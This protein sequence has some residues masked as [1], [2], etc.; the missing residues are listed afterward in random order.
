MTEYAIS[1]STSEPNNHVGNIKI[2]QDDINTQILRVSPTTNNLPTDFT[3]LLV[4]FRSK[5]SDGSVIKEKVT[6]V[7]YKKRRFSFTLTPNCW[8][9]L[10]PI[11]AWFTFERPDGSVV[12]STKN[13]QYTVFEGNDRNIPQGNYI[14]DFEEIKRELDEIIGNEDLSSFV[15]S[16]EEVK[17]DKADR[18]PTEKTLEELEGNKAD[19]KEVEAQFAKIGTGWPVDSVASEAE[20]LTKY[21]NGAD[22]PV[23]VLQPDGKTG[24]VYLWDVATNK[25][26]KGALYQAQGIPDFSITDI[27]VK[28]E[29]LTPLKITGVSFPKVGVVGYNE[30]TWGYALYAN[31]EAKPTP[32]YGVT[33]K[34]TPTQEMMDNGIFANTRANVCFWDA[35]GKVTLVNGG[36][37][38]PLLVPPGTVTM[39][40]TMTAYRMP[41]VTAYKSLYSQGY[42]S[43]TVAK[44]DSEI[45]RLIRAEFFKNR[46]QYL[47]S[48]LLRTGLAKTDNMITADDIIKGGYLRGTVLVSD[49][50][51]NG[52]V[53][54]PITPGKKYVTTST[55]YRQRYNINMEPGLEEGLGSV[56]TEF[57]AGPNE[58]FVTMN[59][60]KNE[61]FPVL[62][63]V[64]G[65]PNFYPSDMF[66]DWVEKIPSYLH[67]KL[68]GAKITINGDSLSSQGDY[69]VKTYGSL[70]AEKYGCTIADYGISGTTL[71]HSHDRH[72][73][74]YH[75]GR[76]DGEAIGYVQNDP[77]TWHTGNCMWE[78]VAKLDSNADVV[79]L[80]GGTNDSAATKGETN[81]TDMTTLFGA[82]NAIFTQFRV[83]YAGKPILCILPPQVKGQ[84]ETL[85][86]NA[87]AELDKKL[88]GSTLTLQLRCEVIR[89]VARKHNIPIIDLFNESGITADNVYYLLN[90]TLHL[91]Q[92]GHDRILKLIEAKLLEIL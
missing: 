64:G 36:W 76:L 2:R 68:K 74:D 56:P 79:F 43:Q 46:A 38:S 59:F 83:K 75:F 17:L 29:G 16:L 14:Y 33:P 27:Q 10:G 13:F 51:W 65:D 77:S 22:G 21:P 7:D 54:Q 37:T 57:T 20:L 25:W 9:R 24:Y 71:A 39:Q 61:K 40:L 8:Q 42:P 89:R 1:L 80:M 86:D 90:D 87:S 6:D 26:K 88:P 60:S 82:A 49:A 73:W 5:W 62:M 66:S 41:V 52:I 18:V 81:S 3:G 12:D 50:N 91:N 32:G 44:N 55:T 92:K 11:N 58:Y 69:P 35:E 48:T 45:S 19:K 23:I 84:T 28:D 4:F 53:P 70:L 34:R 63:E 30:M 47:G 31:G 15:S 67:E 85:V 72:L 78:R